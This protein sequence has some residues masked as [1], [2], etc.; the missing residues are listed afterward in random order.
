MLWPCKCLDVVLLGFLLWTLPCLYQW[1]RSSYMRSSFETRTFPGFPGLILKAQRSSLLNPCFRKG[2]VVGQAVSHPGNECK[3]PGRVLNNGGMQRLAEAQHL[4]VLGGGRAR[5]CPDSLLY[6]RLRVAPKEVKMLKSLAKK[7]LN[8]IQAGS[9]GSVW[10]GMKSRLA[11]D[12]P[13]LFVYTWC[14]WI[15]IC[16]LR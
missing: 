5:S 8:K 14:T 3:S 15:Q 12:G 2:P 11:G 4:W 7:K 13:M 6:S 16:P 1:V 10:A 9:T